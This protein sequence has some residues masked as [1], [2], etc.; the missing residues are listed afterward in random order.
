MTAKSGWTQD[1]KIIDVTN[2]LTVAFVHLLV[3]ISQ[4]DVAKE[5]RQRAPLCNPNVLG[6]EP[7]GMFTQLGEVFSST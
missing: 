1:Y 6:R 5:R 2:A 4:D 7:V 3:E